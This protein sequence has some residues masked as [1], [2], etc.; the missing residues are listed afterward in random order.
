MS[1]VP[2]EPGAE[3]PSGKQ[4]KARRH[5]LLRLFG[6]KLWGWVK[7]VLLCI[8]VGF[9]VMASEFDPANPNVDVTSALGS[10]LST[11]ASAARWAVANFWKPALAG[12]GIVLPIWFLWRLLTLP[13]RK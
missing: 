13:F 10:F 9:L 7:L 11:A 12:A 3:P 5:I 4:P 6:I 1:D 2:A 8:L